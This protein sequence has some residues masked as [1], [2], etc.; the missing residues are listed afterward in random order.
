MIPY[1]DNRVLF[2][3]YVLYADSEIFK[4]N[5]NAAAYRYGWLESMG[6]GIRSIKRIKQLAENRVLVLSIFF[7]LLILLIFLSF[8]GDLLDDGPTY[9]LGSASEA[10]VGATGHLLVIDQSMKTVLVVDENDRIDYKLTGGDAEYSFYYAQHLAED[11]AENIYIVD[12]EYGSRGNLLNS[13]RI[14]LFDGKGYE[15]LWEQDYT[16]DND[17]PLQYST[18]KSIYDDNG[19]IYF[20]RDTGENIEVYYFNSSNDA[21]MCRSVPARMKINDAVY[22]SGNDVIIAAYRNGSVV[23]YDKGDTAGRDINLP[24]GI[25][26]WTMDMANDVIYLSDPNRCCIYTYDLQGAGN[27]RELMTTDCPVKQICADTDADMLLGVDNIACV[28][29]RLSDPGNLEYVSVFVNNDFYITVIIWI[30]AVFT[31][32]LALVFLVFGAIKLFYMALESESVLRILMVVLA[33]IIISSFNTYILMGETKDERMQLRDDSVRVFAELMLSKIDTERL[34]CI[35]SIDSFGS[36]DFIAVKEPLDEMIEV[37]YD[38]G[39]YYYYVIYTTDNVN[40]NSV[41]DYEETVATGG[42]VYEFGDNDYSEVLRTGIP[43]NTNEMSSYGAWSFVLEPI[44]NSSGRI[45]ALLEVG[46]NLDRMQAEQTKLIK[47]MVLSV[48][49]CAVV[50]TMCMLE[51]LFLFNFIEERIE[52]KSI[53]TDDMPSRVPLR[54]L[55]FLSYAAD[56]MQDVFMVLLCTELYDGS[57]PI[58]AGVAIALP[59]SVQLFLMAV[60]SVVGGRLAEKFGVKLSLVSGYILQAAGFII[61]FACGNYYGILVG[62]AFIGMGMGVIYVSCNTAASEADGE[63]SSEK[64]FAGVSAGTLSGLTIGAGI[65]SALL[66]MG[67]YR[68]IYL[69]GALLL[70]IGFIISIL[71]IPFRK[72][73]KAMLE[74]IRTKESAGEKDDDKEVGGTS[75]KSLVWFITRRKVVAFFIMILLPFMMSLSYREYFFPII[76]DG[77]GIS[78]TRIGQIYLLCG[79]VVLYIGPYIANGM[80]KRYGAGRSVVFSSILM[81]AN[82]AI[83]VVFPTVYSAIA[84]VVILSLIISFAYTCQYT[85]FSELNEVKAYGGGK[86]MGIYSMM[87]SAGQTLGPIVYGFLLSFGMV[88]GIMDFMVIMGAL[89]ILFLIFTFDKDSIGR[90]FGKKKKTEVAND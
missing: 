75:A 13:E 19:T 85:Y 29:T 20:I 42:A 86:A 47:E 17:G 21:V 52:K 54:T 48:I 84:G 9:E 41:M 11:E 15:T 36:E 69:V 81:A 32:I 23:Q 28:R 89:V 87:E 30:V 68:L 10:T 83:Y 72:T 51:F 6:K 66:S 7:V 8:F 14:R 22:D 44:R 27:T 39:I 59:M 62:K 2:F 71:M 34:A 18:V 4:E 70:G 67:G 40:I 24:E 79:M 45:V 55:M 88:E 73:E 90:F 33:S 37:G 63:E 65:S 5:I 53:R 58:G 26:P 61:C 46:Q 25:N 78:E 1:L 12:V 76:A 64:A 35:D 50:M 16:A 43:K 74:A 80:I 56:S 82:M 77:A 31:T 49:C 38:S 57:L 3:Y 60:F